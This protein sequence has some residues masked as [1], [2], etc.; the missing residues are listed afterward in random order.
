MSREKT[1]A[2]QRWPKVAPKGTEHP[3]HLE[4]AAACRPARTP[5][6]PPTRAA[7]PQRHGRRRMTAARPAGAAQERWWAPGATLRRQ[8]SHEPYRSALPPL[9]LRA[10]RSARTAVRRAG[11]RVA[12]S[13][14]A[15]SNAGRRSAIIAGF[16]GHF[17]SHSGRPRDLTGEFVWAT[18]GRLRTFNLESR[19]AGC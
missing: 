8:L 16:G 11:G 4:P 14:P 13:A 9:R 10:V 5:R 1:I 15:P 7:P 3:A 18:L 17:T 2:E 19:V 6:R 12:A